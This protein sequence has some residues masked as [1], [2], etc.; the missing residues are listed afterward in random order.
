MR[1][2]RPTTTL[3]L[4]AAAT[5]TLGCRSPAARDDAPWLAADGTRSD[6]RYDLQ[7]ARSELDQ[8]RSEQSATLDRLQQTRQQVADHDRIRQVLEQR[9]ELLAGENDRLQAEVTGLVMTAA[10]VGSTSA[11]PVGDGIA[12][13]GFEVPADLDGRLREFARRYPEV[14][15]EPDQRM[16][17]FRTE[18]MFSGVDLLRPQARQALRD[19]AGLMNRPEAAELNLMVVGH[20]WANTQVSPDMA[21]QTPTDWHLAAHQAIACQ[22]YLE[23]SGLSPTRAGI[24]SYG[25]QQPLLDGGDDVARRRNARVEIFIMPPDPPAD[26]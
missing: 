3:V 2:D 25:S 6:L 16:C 13:V 10:R 9:V 20:T 21:R 11:R 1:R 19:F 22:Q 4:L 18:M 17:R 26:R 15:Y 7:G 14:S 12:L 23:E 24:I 8:I 5:A